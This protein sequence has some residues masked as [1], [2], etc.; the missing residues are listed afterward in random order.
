M[1]F[2]V[3]RSTTG[4]WWYTN[5]KNIAGQA[6]TWAEAF[7]EAFDLATLARPMEPTA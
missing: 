4:I 3:Y 7:A 5:Y 1:K 2:H 6:E